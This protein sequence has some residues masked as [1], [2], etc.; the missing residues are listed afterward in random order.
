MTVLT[1]VSRGRSIVEGYSGDPKRLN[2]AD[3][4]AVDVITDVLLFSHSL[5]GED[6]VA[7]II[8][9]ALANY[10]VESEGVEHV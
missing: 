5:S 2:S 1:A 6:E 8:K 4:S 10:R 9:R 7:R 3:E